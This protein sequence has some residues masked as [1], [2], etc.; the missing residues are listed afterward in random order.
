MRNYRIR[1]LPRV[2]TQSEPSGKGEHQRLRPLLHPSARVPHRLGNELHPQRR[3]HLGNR[4]ETGLR[5]GA[6]GLVQGLAG[7]AG[8]LGH[9]RHAARPG[10]GPQGLGQR[11]RIILF[12]DHRQVFGDGLLVF[13]VL[14]HV[15]IAGDWG[16]VLT[17]A[18]GTSQDLTPEFLRMR[19]LFGSQCKNR[20][21]RGDISIAMVSSK[22]CRA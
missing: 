3:A 5:P 1:L 20:V 14:G 4:L 16:E 19:P 7:Q 13:Q 11:G 8:R 17:C 15:E 10:H 6:Q 2:M 22:N 12:Q 21:Y 18:M 9:L